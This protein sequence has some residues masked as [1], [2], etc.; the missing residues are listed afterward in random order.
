VKAII[1]GGGQMGSYIA[2][3]LIKNGC[4]VKVI[5]NRDKVIERLRKELPDETIAVG[6]GTDPSLLEACGIAETDVVAAVTGTDETNL[7]ASTIAKFEFNVPR[8]IARVNN[9]KNTWLFGREMGV[10]AGLN[11]ADLMARLIVE[12][13]SL[14]NIMT[15]L[16]LDHGGYSIVETVVDARAAAVGRAVKELEIPEHTL[17]IAIFRGAD[18]LIPRGGTVIE[19]GDKLLAFGKVEARAAINALFGAK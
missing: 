3:L 15:L 1:I 19:A 10:D 5:D 18:V 9:P 14:K 4:Q 8:V 13:M 6:S 2:S 17:L 16:E 11:Q 12:E 7:V